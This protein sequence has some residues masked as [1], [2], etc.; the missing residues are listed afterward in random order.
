MGLRFRRSVTLCK[1]VKLNFGKTGMSVSVGQKSYRKTFHQNGNV[2][3]TVGL[4]GTGIYWTDTKR[5]NKENNAKQNNNELPSVDENNRTYSTGSADDLMAQET[6]NKEWIE[7]NIPDT[8]TEEQSKY[9]M[10]DALATYFSEAEEI[11][12]EVKQNTENVMEG[13]VFNILSPKQIYNIYKTADEEV[14]WTEI[15]VS[16][17]P[18]DVYLEEGKWKFFKSLAKKIL[19]GDIEAYLDVIEY[20][21]PLADLLDFGGEFEF[22]TDSASVME[23]EFRVKTEDILGD[24]YSEDLFC[25]YIC[26]T[27]I[28]VARDIMSLLPVG[29]VLIHAMRDNQT[30]LSVLFNRN[31]IGKVNYLNSPQK[32]IQRFRHNMNISEK[33]LSPVNRLNI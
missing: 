12:S 31:E 32:I 27:C 11:I 17:S 30:I 7:H 29:I 19:R 33:R 18:G 14:D 26:A 28:R 20:A 16:T 8:I 2:T 3:T 21:K 6:E 22:G 15:L 5:H 9:Y 25:D 13:A 10:D 24:N 1:G 4:P 23:I